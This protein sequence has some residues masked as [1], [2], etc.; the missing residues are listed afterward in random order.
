M[1]ESKSVKIMGW[2]IADRLEE[3]RP[4][5]FDRIALQ[6]SEIR[7][8][9]ISVLIFSFLLVLSLWLAGNPFASTTSLTPELTGGKTIIWWVVLLAVV[10]EFLD[11]AAGMGYGTAI[12]PML[13][14][15][16]FQPI[17]IV[18]VIMM[19]QAAAGLTSAFLHR[20]FSNVE[21]RMKP[22]SESVRLSLIITI[23][24][25]FA[26]ILSV[27]AVYG[28]FKLSQQW[29]KL[30][31]ALLLVMMGVVSLF[32][33]GKRREYQPGKMIF[34]GALAGFNKGIGGGGYGPVVTIG[35]VLSG[36]PVKTMMAITALSEG[37][38]CVVSLIVWFSLMASGTVLDFALFPSMMLGSLFA[39]V[40]APYA[41]KVLPRKVLS[42]CIPA[43][44]C[45]LAAYMLI[46][47]IGNLL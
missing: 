19:Q 43:Y 39:V 38:V 42:W 44:S 7:A 47:V 16:G 11:S 22:V 33:S 6:K 37:S 35:G 9:G 36:V 28:F 41:V 1:N 17:Q 25:C 2:E 24:G 10:F 32:H 13:L 45:I 3:S 15:V 21:W 34:F 46:K 4:G 18:P 14:A 27:S 40:A 29:I 26:I 5:I 12:T 31:V 20:E 8:I 23:S 30:Y